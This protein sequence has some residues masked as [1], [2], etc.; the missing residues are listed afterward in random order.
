MAFS[1]NLNFTESVRRVYFAQWAQSNYE[2]RSHIFLPTTHMYCTY[3]FMRFLKDFYLLTLDKNLEKISLEHWYIIQN[4]ISSKFKFFSGMYFV[5][6]L[7][8]ST[9]YYIFV[10]LIYKII[11]LLIFFSRKV[12]WIHFWEKGRA[13]Q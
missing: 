10:F 9:G 11:W 8:I 4:I 6:F 5:D 1:E 2:L 7:D 3:H 13:K 12:H